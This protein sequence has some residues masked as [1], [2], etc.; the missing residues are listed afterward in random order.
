MNRN[1]NIGIWRGFYQQVI[2]VFCIGFPLLTVSTWALAGTYYINDDEDWSELSPQPTAADSIFIYD[3]AELTVDVSNAECAAIYIGYDNGS[4]DVE[5]TLEFDGNNAHL[6]VHAGSGVTLGTNSGKGHL[7]MGGGGTLVTTSITVLHTDSKFKYGKGTIVLTGNNTLPAELTNFKHLVISSG[8]TVLDVDIKVKGDLSINGTL[9][10]SSSNHQI[11]L[12]GDWINNGTFVQEKGLVKFSG[13]DQQV[14]TG[15]GATVFNSLELNTKIKGKGKGGGQQKGVLLAAPVYVEGLFELTAGILYSDS[16]NYVTLGP[17]ATTLG[18]SDESYVDGRIKIETDTIKSI[19]IGT[20]K[21]GKHKKTS[22]S[23]LS[24][25]PSIF[26]AEFFDNSHAS[27]INQT[28]GID[29]ICDQQYWE[30]V[31]V[32]GT[33]DATISLYWN[34]TSCGPM[35]LMPALKVARFDSTQWISAG[36]SN[37]VGD[38][39]FGSVT[40]EPLNAYGCFTFGCEHSSLK[41]SGPEDNFSGAQEDVTEKTEQEFEYSLSQVEIEQ[42]SKVAVYDLDMVVVPNP[43]LGKMNVTI[44]GGHGKEVLVVVQDLLGRTHY[45]KVIFPD[46]SEY[47]LA[48]DPSDKLDP[49][50]YLIV[51]SSDNRLYKKKVVIQ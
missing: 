32:S 42:K 2:L 43:S 44:R 4:G 40:S 21:N 12:Q 39:N 5:G 50:V 9:E 31:R 36:S 45:S 11:S 37:L 8:T 25:D 14:I 35:E 51:G 24:T 18:G 22:I 26:V 3:D 41:T 33:A 6:T 10:V 1:S 16:L 38:P 23:T 48:V 46:N 34:S 7:N 30:L 20:G 28:S 49:G 15:S 47:Q 19:V 27:S 29:H 13:S 17:E